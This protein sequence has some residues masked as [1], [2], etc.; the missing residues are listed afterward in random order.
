MDSILKT[1]T[2]RIIQDESANFEAFSSSHFILEKR[3]KP[4][5]VLSLLDK[6]FFII[7]E[8]KK[9]LPFTRNNPERIKSG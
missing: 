3:E 2:D 5:N 8:V 7:A 9:G 6:N 4:V 1:I